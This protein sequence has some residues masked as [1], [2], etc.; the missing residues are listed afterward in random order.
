M[1]ELVPFD[2]RPDARLGISQRGTSLTIP[3][4]LDRD[5]LRNLL[6]SSVGVRT[7]CRLSRTC[8]SRRR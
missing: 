5:P 2:A 4:R 3:E 8:A 7:D 6:A 1:A